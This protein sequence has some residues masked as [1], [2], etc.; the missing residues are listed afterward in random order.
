MSTVYVKAEELFTRLHNQAKEYAPW[1]AL[2]QLDVTKFIENHF[3]DV[4]DWENNF[5]HV[6]QK[7]KELKKL[8]D[9]FKVD[10]FNISLI[11]LKG[12]VEDQLRRFS[13]ALVDSLKDSLER[14]G[15]TVHDFIMK[16]LKKLN[17]NPTSVEEIE[18]MHSDAIQI[19][20]EKEAIARL[21]E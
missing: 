7:R 1:T 9:S 10:C 17:S 2:S 12:A 21:Y 3:K 20:M 14:D 11:P 18:Q 19:G 8:P 5:Q 13:D 6:R 16:G 15:Q 4:A